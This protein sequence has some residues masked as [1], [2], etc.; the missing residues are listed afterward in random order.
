MKRLRKIRKLFRH[1]VSYIRDSSFIINLIA[2]DSKKKLSLFFHERNNFYK[3]KTPSSSTYPYTVHNPYDVLENSEGYEKLF[4]IGDNWLD[5]NSEK[6]I[7]LMIGF[8][9][10][11]YGFTAEYLKEYRVVFMPRKISNLD[12]FWLLLNFEIKPDIFIVWGYTENFISRRYAKL[13][14]IPIFRM[15]DGFIRSAL[16]GASHATPYSLILDKKGLYY[17]PEVETDLEFILNTYDFTENPQLL[18]EAQESL[19]LIVDMKLSKY[20]TPSSSSP[21]KLGIKIK[22]RVVVLGQVDN[23]AAIKYGNPD[24]WSTEEVIKLAR[25]ENPHAEVLYRPHPEVYKGYQKSRFK[26]KRIEYFAKVVSPEEPLLTFLETVD[27]VYTINSLSGLEALLRGI[28]V[29]T[30]GAAFYGGWGLTD[31][32]YKFDRRERTLSLLELFSGVYLKYPRY[33]ASKENSYLGLKAT[34]YKI[35][36]DAY[37][38]NFNV[39]KGHFENKSIDTLLG[40]S[41]WAYFLFNNKDELSIAEEKSIISSNNFKKYFEG[42]SSPLFQSILLYFIAGTLKHEESRDFFVQKVRIY[43]DSEI[44]NQFLYDLMEYYPGDYILKHV[45]WL[46]KEHNEYTEANTLMSQHMM[47][48][49]LTTQDNKVLTLC[50]DN[51]SELASSQD[52]STLRFCLEDTNN[53]ET[54]ADELDM[55]IL[56]EMLENYKT[57]LEYDAFFDIAKK[58]L[59]TNNASTMLFTRLAEVASL[60]MDNSSAKLIAKFVQTID[61][62]AYNRASIHLELENF[63][64]NTSKESLENITKLFILQLKLNPDRINRSWA[65]LKG[66]FVSNNYYNLFSSVAC[67]YSS[68]DIHKSTTYIELN[69]PLDAL[70]ILKYI[71]NTGIISDKLSVE[72]AKVLYILGQHKE[73]SEIICEAVKLEATHANYTEYLRQLKSK[74]EFQ[75]ALDIAEEGVSKKIPLT[76]EGHIMP[77]YFGLG[78]I[79]QGFQCFHDTKLKE[80]L[81]HAFG[82]NKY[83]ET[84]DIEGIDNLLLIFSSGPAEEMRFSSIYN[85]ISES[86]G[87]Q[88]FKMTCDYRLESILSRSFPEI[89]FIPVQRTR[90][91]TPEYPIDNYDKLPSAELCTALDNYGLEYVESS[92]EIKLVSELFFHYRKTYDDFKGKKPHL[93][94]DKSRVKYFKEKLPKDTV[95]VGISWRSSLTNA[96]RNVH[97]LSVEDMEPLFS[98]PNVC[99]VNLQYDECEHE[100]DI[101]RNKYNIDIINFPEL[102]QMNDFDGVAG[103]MKNLDVVISPFTAVVELAGSIGVNSILFSNDGESKWRRTDDNIDVWYDSVKLIGSGVVGDKKALVMDIKHELLEN[104]VH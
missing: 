57:T 72:Y 80:K 94:V 13:N 103:L 62:Y 27:H 59:I 14:D 24:K 36:A 46:L 33:L 6:P 66:Y 52:A 76:N 5:E 49:P 98:I 44:L 8:N 38:E 60:K 40:S 85:E 43:I 86:I 4:F 54:L 7:T 18:V 17:N 28:K 61:I 2:H 16:L 69:R 82:M 58:L 50:S 96:M 9:N 90:F 102:D 12:S 29:T 22:K 92:K 84:H 15:E 32:R 83:R 37:V 19:N 74:G 47:K 71:I 55:K 79:E 64:F 81:I 39:H 25:F 89:T 77:I 34:C 100:L 93:L 41:H 51:T 21:T 53:T 73:A 10:W 1:P 70:N 31:D 20:N 78:Q 104:Y 3:R 87:T 68:L 101:I 75:K 63:D 35:S 91:F 11:K 30:V 48:V 65:I 56:Y 42:N 95:L 67:L 88:N 26:Q 97:Y 99:F 23:D 45:S